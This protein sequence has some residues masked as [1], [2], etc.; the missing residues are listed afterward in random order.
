MVQPFDV[1]SLRFKGEAVPIATQEVESEPVFGHGGFSISRS[2]VVFQSTT[3]AASRFVWVDPVGKKIGELPLEAYR[4]PA[5]SPDGRLI[6]MTSDD[7]RNGK[8]Y[9][10]IYDPA[11]GTW[12]RLSEGGHECCPIWSPNGK[13]IVY[14]AYVNN[15]GYLY[16]TAADGSGTP[17]LVLQGPR[18]FA[19]GWSPDG[20]FL[21]VM[22]F[23]KGPPTLWAYDLK[24][25]KNTAFFTNFGGEGQ[26]SPDGKWVAYVNRGGLFV[27]PSGGGGSRTPID[28]GL[29]GGQPRWTR[30][31]HKLYYIGGDRKV[32]EVNVDAGKGFSPSSPRPLFQTRIIAPNFALFQF[33][34][35]PDGKRFLINSLPEGGNGPLTLVENWIAEIKK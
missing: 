19:N 12:I 21:L 13:T 29:G 2:A 8:T 32:M 22:N 31:G 1:A 24:E 27:Q 11:R 18:L 30:D 3:D 33:D 10:H 9:I 17:Q 35:A 14:S 26:F 6:A 15:V 25:K 16:T 4:D 34:V 5:I 20:R 28:N 7:F 23:E